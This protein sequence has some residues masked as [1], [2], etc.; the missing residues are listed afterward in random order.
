[1][2][3]TK[4]QIPRSIELLAPAANLETA[5]QAI[6]HG[7]DAVY[8]GGP[9][10]GA[11]KAAS[12]TLEDIRQLVEFAHPYRV[13]IYVTLNTLVYE[14]ELE[15]VQALVWDLW[16]AGVD[17][18]IVQDMALLRMDL[19]PI[20]LHA[21][22]QC[23]TRTPEKARF[24][25]DVGFS[26]IVLARELTLQEI[27]NITDTVD[28]PVECFVHGALCVSYSGRCHASLCASGRSAN[29]GECSQMCR[30]KYTLLDND[31]R[32]VVRD[33]H[34]LSLKD[35]NASSNLEAMLKA[36][37]SS[38]KIEGRLKDVEYVK[39]VVGYYR[40][41]LDRIIAAHPEDYRRA[42][43]GESSLT[44]EPKLEKSF[45]RGFTHYFQDERRP[46][47]ISNPLT[48]K[49]MGEEVEDIN[50][51]NT[52]DGISYFD[53][54]GRYDG[55]LVN[56]V[57]R[58]RL[59]TNHPIRLPKGATLYRTYDRLWS[60]Q[61]QRP[62]AE[63]RISLDITLYHNAIEATDERGVRT[64]V[65]W[66]AGTEPAKRPSDL[67]GYFEKLGNTIYALRHFTSHLD[68]SIFVPASRLTALKRQL[69]DAH[70]RTARTIYPED[71][72][73]K[74]NADAKY[75]FETLGYDENVANSLA[76]AFYSEHGVK[77]MENALEID[78]NE[79]KNG[80]EKKV[81]TCRHCILREL[82]RCRKEHRN[83]DLK[84]P[85]YIED[86]V[87][88]YRLNFACDRCEMELYTTPK[89]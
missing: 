48:P 10:H 12:N 81:M 46:K 83:A 37:V 14:H 63:R 3:N 11:R 32:V 2:K 58:G 7:A 44:F 16:R 40:R 53:S 30:H 9:S 68:A 29:R 36:G 8:I 75:P 17:A 80:K 25:E 82:G 79:V 21:S 38:F 78:H 62:S 56:G 59:I 26:Q 71:L 55:A 86:G 5:R 4:R 65:A 43:Y 61:L 67:R 64:R 41:E 76:R 23:D 35:F 88:R 57:Q 1:M 69:L 33:R 28:V 51:L 34:L 24:L 87:V 42:S 20:A 74:E 66:E 45:N 89:S 73:R 47:A 27:K 72:R 6:L 52:G 22:T 50:Q 85:L 49:A 13:K 70:D 19:P 84:F 31:G 60:Q 18:L 15:R 39:N 77:H 54:E